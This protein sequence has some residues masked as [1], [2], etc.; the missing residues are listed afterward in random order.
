MI[1]RTGRIMICQMPHV[2]GTSIIAKNTCGKIT[3]ILNDKCEMYIGAKK[4]LVSTKTILKNW[5]ISLV[6]EMEKRGVPAEFL[7]QVHLVDRGRLLSGFLQLDS[8]GLT[9]ELF[10]ENI[11]RIINQAI[12]ETC[13]Q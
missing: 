11:K 12:M 13:L 9:D 5:D 10:I 7:C 4:H 6:S 3:N 1:I 2:I 8:S